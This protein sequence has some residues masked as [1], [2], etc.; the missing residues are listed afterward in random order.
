MFADISEAD[1]LKHYIA[2]AVKQGYGVLDINVP[3]FL[4][5]IS[6]RSTWFS[7]DESADTT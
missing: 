2:W 5:G 7:F 1:A 6:V 3:K 4:T